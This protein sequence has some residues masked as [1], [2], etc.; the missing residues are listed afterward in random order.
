LSTGHPVDTIVEDN[1]SDINVS[2]GRMDEVI[3]SDRYG[4]A[5]AHDDNHFEIGFRQLHSSGKGEGSTMGRVKGIK[6][7]IDWK[8]SRAPDPGDQND[9]VLFITDPIDGPDEGAQHD[10]DPTPRTPNVWKL[11]IMSKIFMDQ[12]GD[13]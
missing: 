4:I 2:S 5:I 1:S 7:H 13:L 9:L 10:P 6:V 3:S 8:S 11:F 12:L